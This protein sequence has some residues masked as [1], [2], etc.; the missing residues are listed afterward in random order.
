MKRYFY[1]A[2]CIL[3]GLLVATMLH[4]LIEI[5]ALSLIT[6]NF[7]TYGDSFVWRYWRV[8]HGVGGVVLWL[9]GALGGFWAGKRWWQILYIEKR[10]GTP[11]W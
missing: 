6:A 7:D 1:I 9:A 10:Y 3:L 5:P 2:L 8:I 4:G 11:R